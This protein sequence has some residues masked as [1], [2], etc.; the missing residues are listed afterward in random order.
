[1]NHPMYHPQLL[2][3]CYYDATGDILPMGKENGATCPSSS[4]GDP[5]PGPDSTTHVTLGMSHDLSYVPHLEKRRRERIFVGR[6]EDY[7]RYL[8]FQ[9]R[10]H[11][12]HSGKDGS[13]PLFISFLRTWAEP[14]TTEG[15]FPSLYKYLLIAWFE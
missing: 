15:P 7:M 9:L 4:A 5:K 3:R 8:L 2:G 1:M 6:R 14:R 13:L 12:R 10:S 11:C